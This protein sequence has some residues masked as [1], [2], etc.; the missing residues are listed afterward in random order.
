MRRRSSARCAS[1]Y[2]AA[3]RRV[4]RKAL[5]PQ[6][7]PPSPHARGNGAVLSGFEY[8]AVLQHLHLHRYASP[9][10]AGTRPG[11]PSGPASPPPAA[12]RHRVLPA[13]RFPGEGEAR[14][15]C[16]GRW[17]GRDPLGCQR[18]SP[19]PSP[20]APGA[21]PAGPRP[22][23]WKCAQTRPST[24]KPTT[25]RCVGRL[26]Q[27]RAV[28]E[29]TPH[30]PA[31]PPLTAADGVASPRPLRRDGERGQLC[32]ARHLSRWTRH[33]ARRERLGAA[34]RAHRC[35]PGTSP[36]FSAAADPVGPLQSTRGQAYR[37]VA[38]R[39]RDRRLAPPGRRN[40]AVRSLHER[41]STPRQPRPC[42][43]PAH[44]PRPPQRRRRLP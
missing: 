11:L 43:H 30:F 27:A 22:P 36:L 2:G 42:A 23:K 1:R 44:L 14:V 13:G 12:A 9:A 16:S 35:V 4:L 21:P 18:T 19:E 17:A 40:H 38:M 15:R 3:L 25:R 41:L 20:C 29:T 7:R 28:S 37:P 32:V 24:R 39:L 5:V 33:P 6:S 26:P 8:Y 34:A 31:S 10:G